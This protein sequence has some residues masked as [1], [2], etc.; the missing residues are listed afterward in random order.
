M[1]FDLLLRQLIPKSPNYPADNELQSKENLFFILYPS[2]IVLKAL[3][4]KTNLLTRRQ[5]LNKYFYMFQFEVL[6]LNY[7]L[8][9]V[10]KMMFRG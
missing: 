3:K 10:M 5:Q 2:S 7:N 4:K 9:C 8:A 1:K 6:G